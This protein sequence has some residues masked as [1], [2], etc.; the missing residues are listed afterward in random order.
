MLIP[1]L[2]IFQLKI[3][4]NGMEGSFDKIILAWYGLYS[5]GLGVP[6]W[7]A[8]VYLPLVPLW[9]APAVTALSQF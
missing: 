4:R 5:F 9:L 8:K 3:A 2:A 1:S 7:R 6:F